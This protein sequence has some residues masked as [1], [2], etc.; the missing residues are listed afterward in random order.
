[1]ANYTS[2]YKKRLDDIDEHIECLKSEKEEVMREFERYEEEEFDKLKKKNSL[3]KRM[4]EE[5]LH[6]VFCDFM[7]HPWVVTKDGVRVQHISYEEFKELSKE[8]YMTKTTKKIY[9]DPP[10][11]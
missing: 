3:L 11:R 1:M 9:L 5:D 2:T 10:R 6:I 8:D 4:I 7:S